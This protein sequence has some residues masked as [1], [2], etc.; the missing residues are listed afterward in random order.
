M[1]GVLGTLHACKS[2]RETLERSHTGNAI[3]V[4][5]ILAGRQVHEIYIIGNTVSV[6]RHCRTCRLRP[7]DVWLTCPGYSREIYVMVT[8][9]VMV[10]IEEQRKRFLT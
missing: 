5:N 3:Y 6:D 2:S 4:V 8:V 1:L 7:S 9:T 10:G